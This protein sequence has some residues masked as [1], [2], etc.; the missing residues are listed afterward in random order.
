MLA[1]GIDERTFTLHWLHEHESAAAEQRSSFRQ[2]HTAK[3]TISYTI[4]EEKRPD[5]KTPHRWSSVQFGS[6]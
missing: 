3:Y 2:C 1:V 4:L 5:T 6:S